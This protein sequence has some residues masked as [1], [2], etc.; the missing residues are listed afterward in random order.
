MDDHACGGEV[1]RASGQTTLATLLFAA[2][3][4]GGAACKRSAGRSENDLGQGGI[5][6][7]GAGGASAT[8]GNSTGAGGG[9]G[10]TSSSGNGGEATGGISAGSGGDLGAGGA[11]PSSKPAA[12]SASD[13]VVEPNPNNTLSCFVSWSTDV[14]ANSEVQFGVGGYQFHIVTD[15]QV[16]EHRVLVIGMHAETSYKIRAVS[17]TAGGSAS[18]EGS[19]TTGALPSG[20]P[21]GTQTVADTSAAQSGWTLVNIMPASS[22]AGF[23]GTSSG[24]IAMY[25]MQGLPVWY[26]LNGTTVDVRGDV[27]LRML[28]NQHVML[29]PS[30]GEPAKEIDLAGNVLWSGPA[31]PPSNASTSDPATAPMSHFAN[32]LSNGNYILFRDLTNANGIGGALLQEL[33]T[34]N[35]V[36]WSWNL[37]DHMQPPADAAKD[38]CHPNSV[39]VDLDKDVFYLSCRFLGIIKAKR[40]GDKAVVWVLGGETGGDF[41][42]NPSSASFA[43]QHDP[44]IHD[45]G[46]VLLYSNGGVDLIRPAGAA[47]SV[48]E[49]KLDE[50]TMQAT[51]TFAFPGN[52]DVDSWY[53]QDWYTPYW[54]DADRLAN[55]DV[56]VVAGTRS[57]SV[58][59][60]IFEVR[61]SDGQVVWQL[62]FPAGVGSYQGER[63]SPPPLVEPM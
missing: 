59:T 29:G 21:V 44:E 58:Q 10:G 17:S 27:S 11:I 45:D 38:W 13:L 52:F 61:P 57:T 18:V 3:V 53:K 6:G 35:E 63:L 1:S 41:T 8:G 26:F 31:Q 36:V 14:A 16:T 22:R 28:A 24:M 23:N 2:S 15:E 39:T 42:F 56:L 54:G 9:S 33:S 50:G 48:L 5:G 46:T 12:P 43:D 32:K 51:P 47:S 62:T 30:S 34:S 37:F 7:Q 25:D 55:G 49:V 60:H 40:S 19:F 20:L 4:I